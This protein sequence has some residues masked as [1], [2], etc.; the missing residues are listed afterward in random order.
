MLTYADVKRHDRAAELRSSVGS[1]S[2][3]TSSKRQYPVG[4]TEPWGG[5]GA[6]GGGRGGGG[7]G[8]EGS[9]GGVRRSAASVGGGSKEKALGSMLD[10]QLDAEVVYEA[11]SYWCMLSYATSV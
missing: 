6:G 3:N 9:S 11:L 10:Y 5:K 1:S 2:A 8:R 7:R 4:S